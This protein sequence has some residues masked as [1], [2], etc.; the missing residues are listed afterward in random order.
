MRHRQ[1]GK[2]LGRNSSHRK[3]M[4]RNMI[5]ALI[6]HGRI[7]TTITKAKEL[8]RFAEKTITWGISLGDIL[9]KPVEE[10]SKEQR[11]KLV[12]HYRMAAR[13]VPDK[14]L[15]TKLFKEVAPAM[16]KRDGEGGYTRIVKSYPRRGDNAP[17]A[18]IE[19]VTF[20]KKIEEVE[21]TK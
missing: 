14:K 21:E 15:L 2:I 13:L 11:A 3:A 4:Y 1:S 9:G 19:L 7:K 20:E 17:M 18:L 8:R 6:E 10:L 16:A 5:S 12:H